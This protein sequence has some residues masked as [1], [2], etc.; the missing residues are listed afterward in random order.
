MHGWAE[1]GNYKCH[2]QSN[3][4]NHRDTDRGKSKTEFDEEAEKRRRT[5]QGIHFSPE[6]KKIFNLK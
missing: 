4:A 3:H 1:P 6:R 2:F 5:N